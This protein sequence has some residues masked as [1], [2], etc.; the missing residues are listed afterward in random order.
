MLKKQSAVFKALEKNISIS[1]SS[2]ED[3]IGNSNYILYR[4]SSVVI[5]AVLLGLSPMCFMRDNELSMDP[6]FLYQENNNTLI[7]LSILLSGY[8]G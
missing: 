8:N 1:D 4:G 5:Q 3:D 7:H 2:L 6:L